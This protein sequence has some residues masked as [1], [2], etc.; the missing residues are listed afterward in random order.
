MEPEGSLPHSH[1]SVTCFC[2]EPDESNPTALHS[3]TN[4]MTCKLMLLLTSYFVF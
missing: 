3:V 4:Y 1:Q 2:P